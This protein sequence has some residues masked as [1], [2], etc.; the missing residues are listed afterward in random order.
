MKDA[1]DFGVS[2]AR[3]VDYVGGVLQKIETGQKWGKKCLL[4]PR[5]WQNQQSKM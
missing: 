5:Y 1:L 2:N 4:E 3:G